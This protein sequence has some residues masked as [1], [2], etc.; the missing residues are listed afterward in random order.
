M[1]FLDFR[2]KIRDKLDGRGS[3]AYNS[4]D[5][6]LQLNGR[7]PFGGM[8]GGALEGFKLLWVER[9]S[10]GSGTVYPERNPAVV[11]CNKYTGLINRF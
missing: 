4:N 8:N 1:E 11:I 5:L 10:E 2:S 7:V 3:R 9:E 6:V